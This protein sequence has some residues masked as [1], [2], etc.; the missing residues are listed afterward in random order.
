M[1]S[2]QLPFVSIL[3]QRF[4]EDRP[5][6]Q[7]ILG[8]RQVGKTT[9]V[10]QFLDA[11]ANRFVFLSADNQ[12]NNKDFI[13]N[14]WMEAKS[15]GPSTL[16]VI[17][18]IQKIPNWS[19]R[20][21]KIWDE[22]KLS[23]HPPMKLLLL[24]SSS[25]SIQNGL[26]ESLAGRY[27]L[28][29]VPHW[30]YLESKALMPK[31]SLDEYLTFGGYPGTYLFMNDPARW[32]AYVKKSIIDQ[33]VH[34]DI[35]FLSNVKKPAL[36]RQTFDVLASYPSQEISYRKLLGQIQEKGN[37]DLIKYYIDLYEGAYLF[38]ALPKYGSQAFKVKTSSPKILP[39]CPALTHIYSHSPSHDKYG[40]NFEASVGAQLNRLS[41]HLFYW[42]D[43][44]HEVDFIFRKNDQLFAIEV[45]SG[46]NKRAVGL[47]AFCKL[48]QAKPILITVENYSAFINNADE[49]LETF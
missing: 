49:F 4:A 23:K 20:T 1:K 21:K 18:E 44:N 42:R 27:E 14:A 29:E 2:F 9:G 36:F 3:E 34:Q 7:V 15:K 47:Q 26:T 25:M 40:F 17:D 33:V 48:H 13:F 16:L 12:A 35:L 38:K 41:G 43:G 10:K 37:T 30:N 11:Y 5:L 6:I 22:V 39:L 24:G 45:K 8:P 32:R 28:I 46:R 19:E 31:L